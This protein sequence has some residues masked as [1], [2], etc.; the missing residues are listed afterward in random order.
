[1]HVFSQSKK[2]EFQAVIEHFQGDLHALRTGRANPAILESIKLMAYDAVMDI[3]SVA[4]INV[5]DARTMTVEPWDASLLQAVEKAIRE[6]DIGINPAVDG[7]LVRVVVPQMTEES[8]K[9][10]VKNMH[11]KMEETKIKLRSLREAARDAVLEM[12]KNKEIA[13]DEKYKLFEDIDRMTKEFTQKV[14]AM[15][16]KKESE[17]MT[18]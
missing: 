6:A 11:E 12:E 10:L 17:I 15:A 4:A 16:E 7:R 2:P 1:M 3:K 13:E 9:K 5:Q 18:V 14:D 8:R